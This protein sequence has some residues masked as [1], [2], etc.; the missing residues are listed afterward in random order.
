MTTTTR[1]FHALEFSLF[2]LNGTKTAVDFSSRELQLLDLL[3][4]DLKK[5]ADLLSSSWASATGSFYDDFRSAGSDNSSYTTVTAA[6]GEVLGSM[7]D[8][9]TEL[10]DSKIQ[11]PLDNQDN[12]YLESRFADYSLTDYRNNVQGTY[13]VYIGNM[14]T[15]KRKRASAIWSPLPIQLLTIKC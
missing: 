9:M 3:S 12:A 15:S 2:G 10:P 1:G 5:Q 4:A 13:N 8:I 11:I 14:A 6:L 7:A